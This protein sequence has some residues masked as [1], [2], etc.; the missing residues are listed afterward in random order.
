MDYKDNYLKK[1]SIYLR[2]APLESRDILNFAVYPFRGEGPLKS[3]GVY[4]EGFSLRTII[5][6]YV[7][8]RLSR[9][10]SFRWSSLLYSL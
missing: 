7:E 3:K 6:D 9:L 4:A 5:M 10:R 1:P 2:G 8:G